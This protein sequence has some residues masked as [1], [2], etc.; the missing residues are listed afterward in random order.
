LIGCILA[1]AVTLIAWLRG[2]AVRRSKGRVPG[3]TYD[4]DVYGM[5]VRTHRRYAW[6]GL[7]FAVF[8]GFTCALHQSAAGIAGLAVYALIAILYAT[9]FLRGASDPD[10]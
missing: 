3:L 6:T 7:A 8:F 10:E 4:L 2:A 9:S 5:T 1:L